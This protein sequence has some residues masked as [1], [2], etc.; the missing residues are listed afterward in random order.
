MLMK[1]DR[2]LGKFIRR[3]LWMNDPMSLEFRMFFM[4]MI[5]EI[6]NLSGRSFN[7]DI[8]LSDLKRTITSITEKYP[9]LKSISLNTVI[10]TMNTMDSISKAGDLFSIASAV[11][12]SWLSIGTLFIGPLPYLLLK[13]FAPGRLKCGVIMGVGGLIGLEL[14]DIKQLTPDREK[15]LIPNSAVISGVSAPVILLIS[16]L[17][18]A[19]MIFIKMTGILLSIF[20]FTVFLTGLG[21]KFLKGHKEKIREIPS[22]DDPFRFKTP[23]ETSII[24]NF[25]LDVEE[26]RFLFSLY[27]ALALESIEIT[28]DPK[29]KADKRIW[30]DKWKSD[31][32]NEISGGLVTDLELMKSVI[33]GPLQQLSKFKIILIL[34]ECALYKPFFSLNDLPDISIPIRDSTIPLKSL[35]TLAQEMGVMF[36]P[37]NFRTVYQNSIRSLNSLNIIKQIVRGIA[38]PS[39]YISAPFAVISNEIGIIKS[40]AG[41]DHSGIINSSELF[42]GGGIILEKEMHPLICK[43]AQSSSYSILCQAA[44]LET[45]YKTIMPGSEDYHN[46]LKLVISL[47]TDL[48]NS[49]VKKFN[50]NSSDR[51][52]LKG[53]VHF[54]EVSIKRAQ[55]RLKEVLKG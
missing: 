24:S 29:I 6:R 49:L 43:I 50:E 20:L 38:L 5:T 46:F 34:M 22:G 32:E 31:V 3:A 11:S 21:L 36:Q 40:P 2:I 39:T 15:M 23:P 35:N 7:A 26:S 28:S 45:I 12:A 54:L 48:R 17:A 10:K 33:S 1:Y 8:T 47:E 18:P 37:G 55:E 16:I 30:I 51:E 27:H 25:K 14:Y 52:E 53:S 19:S 9:S 41:F 13:V 44:R 4:E 42:I